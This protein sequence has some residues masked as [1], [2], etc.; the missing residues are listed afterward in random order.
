MLVKNDIESPKSDKVKDQTRRS[1]GEQDSYESDIYYCE[2][3]KERNSLIITT[4]FQA[5]KLYNSLITFLR[6]QDF[7]V[8][9]YLERKFHKLRISQSNLNRIRN[10]KGFD[11]L[12]INYLENVHIYF[13]LKNK[14]SIS[15]TNFKSIKTWKEE[16]Q[17]IECIDDNT[18]KFIVKFI[19]RLSMLIVKWGLFD[20]GKYMFRYK[21]RSLTVKVL[22]MIKINNQCMDVDIFWMCFAIKHLPFFEFIEKNL[23]NYADLLIY[24]I[25]KVFEF[26]ETSELDLTNTSLDIIPKWKVLLGKRTPPAVLELYKLIDA[27]EKAYRAFE[28]HIIQ[29]ILKVVI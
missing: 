8:R 9:G 14:V 3:K 13:S 1:D 18:H 26:F 19:K 29:E 12:R 16:L 22:D 25:N 20:I 6:R 4:C 28:K 5:D 17:E 21:G 11:L 23:I 2:S 15:E 27:L 10:Q 7:L 24:S